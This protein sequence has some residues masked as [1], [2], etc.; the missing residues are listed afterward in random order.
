[1][2]RVQT[3][4]QLT[5]DLLRDARRGGADAARPRGRRSSGTCSPRFL[6]RNRRRRKSHVTSRDIAGTRHRPSTNGAIST[7]KVSGTAP[8]SCALS[9]PRRMRRANRGDARR[10]VVVRATARAGS[11]PSRLDSQRGD[12]DL[13]HGRRRFQ[14]HAP[15]GTSR[16]RSTLIAA[17]A[18]RRPARSRSINCGMSKRRT[19]PVASPRWPPTAGR[20]CA[21]R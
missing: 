16:P 6:G 21:R 2:A 12:S 5:D 19:S 7:S 17:T 15:S 20:R 9:R 13:E 18:C 3:M 10:C 4:V 14:R 8:G 1:M 11:T